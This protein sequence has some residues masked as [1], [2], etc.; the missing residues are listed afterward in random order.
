MSRDTNNNMM[1]T[2]N[3]EKSATIIRNKYTLSVFLIQRKKEE[4]S[5]STHFYSWRKRK[6]N[7]NTELKGMNGYRNKMKEKNRGNK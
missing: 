2:S 6:E 7:V 4:D 5:Y 3:T 1:M